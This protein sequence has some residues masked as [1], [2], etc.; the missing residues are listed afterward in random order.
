MAKK[1][2]SKK[3]PAAKKQALVVTAS[4]DRSIH[5]VAHD[6][7]AAGFEVGHRQQ[8]FGEGRQIRRAI[9]CVVA[10]RAAEHPHRNHSGGKIL[11]LFSHDCDAHHAQPLPHRRGRCV[12]SLPMGSIRSRRAEICLRK[13]R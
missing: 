3:Q 7:K 10:R 5:E 11:V 9:A 8:I 1:Q 2:A 4:G 13:I 6:L 12:E